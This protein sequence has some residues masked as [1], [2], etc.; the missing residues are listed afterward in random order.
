MQKLPLARSMDIVVQELEKEI[1]VYDL[2]TNKAFNLN[3]TSAA[4]YRAC[5]GKTTVEE[6]K[7]KY[8]FTDELIFLALDQLKAENL[9]R[10]DYV[11]PLA[12]ITRRETIRKIGLTT[13]IALPVVSSLVAPTAAMAQS[14]Q[15]TVNVGAEGS[16]GSCPVNERCVSSVC[17]AC[18][19][20]G[21]TVPNT[22]GVPPALVCSI[23]N[24]NGIL[25]CCTS[26]CNPAT[27]LCT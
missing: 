2:K 5:N 4:V 26:S 16:Q 20:S 11:S 13:M 10:E 19:P 12:G 24:L 8:K 17:V 25:Q 7:S 27:N 14:A 3:E 1:L 23:G 6:L 21:S 18:T 9:I 22:A 15:C